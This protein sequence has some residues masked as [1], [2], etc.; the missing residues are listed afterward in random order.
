MIF[1]LTTHIIL[2]LAF[3]VNLNNS[4][5][6]VIVPR[7]NPLPERRCHE[8]QKVDR[9][10]PPSPSREETDTWDS[11]L[12]REWRGGH[13]ISQGTEHTGLGSNC[14]VCLFFFT[15]LLSCGGK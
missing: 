13:A 4:C 6:T 12:R 1:T 9:V 11:T 15:Y 5:V 3:I 7:D 2:F 14:F 8:G 10:S